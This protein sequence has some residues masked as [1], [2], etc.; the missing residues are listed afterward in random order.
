MGSLCIHG[1]GTPVRCGNRALNRAESHFVSKSLPQLSA[2]PW[3]PLNG[4]KV[5]QEGGQRPLGRSHARQMDSLTSCT[6]QRQGSHRA[7]SLPAPNLKDLISASSTATRARKGAH[8]ARCAV[9]QAKCK[10]T[11]STQRRARPLLS[12]PSPPLGLRSLRGHEARGPSE[13]LGTASAVS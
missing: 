8:G 9:L 13:P 12:G 2:T 10:P 6:A 11:A 4:S 7:S 5:L 1:P 3:W